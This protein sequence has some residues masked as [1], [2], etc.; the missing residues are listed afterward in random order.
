MHQWNQHYF[1]V[2]DLSETMC[3]L[4]T[5]RA[6]PVQR[7][8]QRLTRPTRPETSYVEDVQTSTE[9]DNFESRQEVF[10]FTPQLSFFLGEKGETCHGQV[11]IIRTSSCWF[12]RAMPRNASF[13]LRTYQTWRVPWDVGGDRVS[14]QFPFCELMKWWIPMCGGYV[15]LRF[16]MI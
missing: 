9:A 14:Q 13:G 12:H 15:G 1:V 2:L 4:A 11:K 5:H 7:R 10:L 16:G 3:V 6:G 8:P